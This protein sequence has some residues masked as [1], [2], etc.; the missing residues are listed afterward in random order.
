MGKEKSPDAGAENPEMK[1]EKP[2][3]ENQVMAD[4]DAAVKAVQMERDRVTKIQAICNGEYNEIE[5]QAISA[6]WTPEETSQKV[7]KALRENRPAADVNIT[8]KRRPQGAVMRKSLE[9]AMCL[10]I[11]ISE[12][13]LL[14]QYGDEALDRGYDLSDIP[15]KQVL[16][17]CLNMEGINAP[18]SF[19]NETIQAAF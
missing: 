15:M 2:K 12:T 16:V 14:A 11:G 19:G 13:E 4:A 3:G 8:V 5:K 6:G 18:S 17:E 1:A 10:R 7:L 9:A